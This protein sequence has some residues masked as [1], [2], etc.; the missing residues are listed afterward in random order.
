ML[1]SLPHHFLKICKELPPCN[2]P[3]VANTTIPP[4][5]SAYEWSNACRRWGVECRGCG[6]VFVGGVECV[7]GCR[8]CVEGVVCIPGVVNTTIPPG[9]SA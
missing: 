3:G 2:I 9:M 7:V 8:G 6:G 4:G 1:F 5:M